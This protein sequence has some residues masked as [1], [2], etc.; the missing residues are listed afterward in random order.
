MSWTADQI[1]P[2][3]GTT[4]VVTGANSGLGL[5]TTRELARHGATVILACRN[6]DK[7]A[8]AVDEI[9]AEVPTADLEL[10]RLDLSDLASVRAFAESLESRTLDTLVNNAGLMAV[11]YARTADDFEIQ[12]GTN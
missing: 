4:V 10:G 7:A 5:E 2:L 1:Q 3:S 8:A 12:M 9:R 6:Q 11:P